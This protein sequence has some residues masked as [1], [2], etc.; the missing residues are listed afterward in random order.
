MNFGSAY[1]GPPGCVHGGVIAS[2]FDEV[3]GFAQSMTG[4]PGMTGTL[5]TKY[6]QPTPLRTELRFEASVTR[7]QGRKNFAEARLY[8]GEMLC[9]EAEAIFISLS[10]ERYAELVEAQARREREEQVP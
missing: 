3:L 7:S 6:R 8:A 9:A 4:R 2:A 10:P 5:V 1:E